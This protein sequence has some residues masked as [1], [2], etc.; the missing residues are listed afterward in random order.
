M[1]E[2]DNPKFFTMPNGT[3]AV[4]YA[5]S[6]R[7]GVVVECS[8]HDATIRSMLPMAYWLPVFSA[9]IDNAKIDRI[10]GKLVVLFG[11][12]K[13]ND[14]GGNLV[15]Y[16]VCSRPGFSPQRMEQVVGPLL[17]TCAQFHIRLDQPMVDIIR[18]N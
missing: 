18:G 11:F 13:P 1:M 4:Q 2:W 6:D 12:G 5:L 3:L 17:A 8:M 10:G 16:R 7:G 9:T 14:P 15:L